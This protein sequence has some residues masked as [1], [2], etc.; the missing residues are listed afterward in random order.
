[1]LQP[2]DKRIIIKPIIQEK[3]PSVLL[4]KDETPQSF[5]VLAIGDDVKKVNIGDKIL[6]A[7]FSTSEVTYENVK[8]TIVNETNIIAK[9]TV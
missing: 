7:S 4:L 5:E 9:I 3:K 1:M 6:I 8:Y 2:L